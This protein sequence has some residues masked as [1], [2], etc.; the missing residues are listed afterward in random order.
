M[1]DGYRV[2]EYESISGDLPG[3]Q[4]NLE[5]PFGKLSE[6]IDGVIQNNSF[7]GDIIIKKGK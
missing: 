4:T 5:I 3:G 6:A 1:V 7:N 2:Y